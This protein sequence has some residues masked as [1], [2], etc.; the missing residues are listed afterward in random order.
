[1]S[2]S[3]APVPDG[4]SGDQKIRLLL[5]DDI[6]ETRENLRKLLFFESDIEV[7]G[8]AIEV[9]KTLGP[10]LLESAYEECLC[11]ELPLR[12]LRFERQRR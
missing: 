9:H 10:G 11:H 5:V 8:A 2:G 12:K 6:P 1:M 7:I 4:S 3:V